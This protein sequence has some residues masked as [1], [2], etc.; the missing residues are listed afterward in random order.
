MAMPASKKSTRTRATRR[1]TPRIRTRELIDPRDPALKNAYTLLRQSFSRKERVRLSEWRGTMLEQKNQ[2]ATD[3]TWHLLVSEIDG[4][5]VGL[6]SGTYLGN[7]NLAMVGYLAI[8]PEVRALGIGTRLRAR[9]RKLLER[10]ARRITGRPL[11]AILGE[12]SPGNPWLATLARRPSVLVLDFPYYQPRMY[13]DDEPSPFMLYYES[14]GEVRERIPVG[15]L[16]RILFSIWRRVYRVGRPLDRP[17]FRVMLRA[18]AGRR[19]IGR[20]RS[21]QRTPVA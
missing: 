15:E 17:A 21:P 12:V 7:V 13:V 5:V 8:A 11:A 6:A 9:L 10:D 1:P 16:R 20:T 19:T 14:L 3:V 2:L 4:R 18:L